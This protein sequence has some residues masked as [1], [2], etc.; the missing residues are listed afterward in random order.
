MIE[1]GKRALKKKIQEMTW[2]VWVGHH[3]WS[4]RGGGKFKNGENIC[5][6]CVHLPRLGR[7]K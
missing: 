4:G 2:E 1:K 5:A 7:A 3:A 6:G